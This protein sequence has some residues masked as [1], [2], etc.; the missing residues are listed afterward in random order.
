MAAVRDLYEI[1]GI[2]RD[3]SPAEIKA[4]YRKLARTLHPDVNAD[5]G[6]PGAVQGDHR[7]LRDPVRPDEATALRRVRRRRAAGRSVRR[8]PGHLRHVL[9]WRFRRPLA[10]PSLP[11]ASG[12]GPP[13]PRP[14]DVPRVGLR[15]E[16][17]L[18]IERLAACERC[19]GIGAEPGTSPVPCRTC[20]GTSTSGDA[21]TT[22]ANR[23]RPAPPASANPPENPNRE[24]LLVRR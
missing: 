17:R 24:W 9:R 16:Q 4:A 19:G 14:S 13:D 6:G 21:N 20:G 10:R 3:A 23:T 22:R 5:P 12:G 15:R 11:G 1:L 18:E 8:H 2:A 7:R